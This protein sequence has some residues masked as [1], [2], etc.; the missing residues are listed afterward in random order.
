[1]FSY[2]FERNHREQF[3]IACARWMQR[4]S[5]CNNGTHTP[6]FSAFPAHQLSMASSCLPIRCR[7]LR[8][9]TSRE[10]T[11]SSAAT[12][13]RVSSLLQ[14]YRPE[15]IWAPDFFPWKRLGD[16][17][18]AF[19]YHVNRAFLCFHAEQN[20]SL[21]KAEKIVNCIPPCKPVNRLNGKTSCAV[22]RNLLTWPRLINFYVVWRERERGNL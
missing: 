4:R 15:S 8:V 2:R 21:D 10:S 14:S 19:F 6:G 11:F 1:M 20:K 16:E 5:P 17:K 9:Q 12:V 18:V 7:C 3:W 22:A 13:M